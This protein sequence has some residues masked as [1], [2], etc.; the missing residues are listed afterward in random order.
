M[1]LNKEK[2]IQQLQLEE[3]VDPD[4][5]YYRRTYNSPY[6]VSI[7]KPDGST[8]LRKTMTSIYFML[9]EDRKIGYLHKNGCDVILYYQLGLPIK[10]TLLYPNGKL[11]ESVLG[12]GILSGEKLQLYAPAGV[13]IGS[14]LMNEAGECDYGLAS[15]AASPGFEYC[16][17]S[18]ATEELVKSLHPQ[19]W[20][21]LKHLIPP[22]HKS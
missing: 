7:P 3:L 22:I 11:E 6:T 9:S 1:D 10:F 16:D 12:P 18:L 20:E 17:M 21:T 8:V 2:V 15:E 4:G 5:G 14:V 19:H 13:W